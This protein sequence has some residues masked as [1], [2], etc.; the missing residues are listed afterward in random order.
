MLSTAALPGRLPF[1][2]VVVPCHGLRLAREIIIEALPVARRGSMRPR[3][4]A[5][6]P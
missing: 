3:Q 4:G 5:T 6:T 2:G 1:N